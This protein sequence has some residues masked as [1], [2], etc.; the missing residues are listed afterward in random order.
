MEYDVVPP[1]DGSFPAFSV[2]RRHDSIAA[3]LA[4]SMTNDSV[5][6]MFERLDGMG[7]FDSNDGEQLVLITDPNGDD[8]ILGV[9]PEGDAPLST[10]PQLDNATVAERPA[11]G[12][13]PRA[14]QPRR[15]QQK[16]DKLTGGDTAVDGV[17]V[18]SPESFGP[19][20]R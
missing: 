3:G 4:S 20:A 9:D 14:K 17:P 1:D 10:G 8:D 16:I 5:N 7:V 13:V 19:A 15:S 18:A 2:T 6:A 11:E 12:H